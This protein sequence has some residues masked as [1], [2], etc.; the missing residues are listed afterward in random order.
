MNTENKDDWFSRNWKWFIPVICLPGITFFACLFFG[1]IALMKSSDAYQKGVSEAVANTELQEVIGLPII[2]GFIMKGS[3]NL[4]NDNGTAN[5]SI[6][7]S[8]PK[9]EATIYVVGQKTNGIWSYSH[10]IARVKGRDKEIDLL[11]K[12]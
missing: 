12:E 4:Q 7:I 10:L 6:P 5:L 9:G 3:I 1:V 2:E 11:V 8:G